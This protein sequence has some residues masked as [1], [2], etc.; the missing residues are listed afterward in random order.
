MS[1]S[2]QFDRCNLN[3]VSLE[4]IQA[5]G[6]VGLIDFKRLAEREELAGA[7]NFIDLAIVPAGGSIGE[8]RH[9][10]TE[11]EFY[12][13]LGGT[14]L[15]QRNGDAFRVRP[16]DLIRNPPGGAHSL[17]NDG[18]DPLRIFV[19]ELQAPGGG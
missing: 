16:G 2:T 11:E 18:V 10:D 8:H 1:K 5:H 4:K 7:C 13:I 19:F 14:G 3:D 15:M 12:L 6:G 17:R 9:Q